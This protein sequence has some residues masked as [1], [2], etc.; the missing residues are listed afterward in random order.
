MTEEAVPPVVEPIAST[1]APATVAE[2]VEDERPY[3]AEMFGLAKKLDGTWPLFARSL[4]PATD[5]ACLRGRYRAVAA[6]TAR[7]SIR[8]R[9]AEGNVALYA[10]LLMI[11]IVCTALAMVFSVDSWQEIIR[12]VGGLVVFLR[13]AWWSE[14]RRHRPLFRLLVDPLVNVVGF[15]CFLVAVYGRYASGPPWVVDLAGRSWMPIAQSIG[16]FC[17]TT[18]LFWGLVNGVMWLWD[19]ESPTFPAEPLFEHLTTILARTEPDRRG[20]LPPKARQEILTLLAKVAVLLRV[21]IPAAARGGTSL[22]RAVVRARAIEASRAV[23]D[24]QLWIA[25]PSPTTYDEFRTRIAEL[26]RTILTGEYDRLPSRE[27]TPE[28][29]RRTWHARVLEAARTLI[30]ALVPLAVLLIVHRLG[31]TLPSPFDDG[32]LI[33]ALAW[34]VV[35]LLG[36][37]DPNFPTHLAAVR[38]LTS[39][40]PF[41]EKNSGRRLSP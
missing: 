19:R 40:N 17:A 36:L 11:A 32:A 14:S 10:L 18:V 27:T 3:L 39:L 21:G 2:P 26:T 9:D 13:I 30:I 20:H 29:M 8:R 23:I 33:A 6:S 1:T 15:G 37:L 38:D 7:W 22:T 35:L 31:L 16:V 25:L 34:A 4:D 28:A 12:A 24:L 5:P 41:T